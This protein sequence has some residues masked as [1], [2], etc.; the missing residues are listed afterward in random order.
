[1]I[2]VMKKNIL[3]LFLAVLSVC[4]LFAADLE[5][6]DQHYR[7]ISLCSML[8]KHSEDKFAKEIEEHF[9]VIP[10]SEQYNDHNL[11]VRVV[12]VDKKGKYTPNIHNFVEANEIASR[13]VAKW[14]NRNILTGECDV[15]LVKERGLYDASAFDIELSK[16]S[17]RG[18]AMLADAGED[19]IGRT[20]LLVNEIVYIDKGKRSRTWGAVLGALTAVAG[21]A[22]GVDTSDLADLTES[23]IS[24]IKGFKVKINTRLYRLNW[25][26]ENQMF[27]YSECYSEGKDLAKME[28]FEKGRGKFSMTYVG[29]VTSKGST[30]SFLGI[31]EDQPELMIRKACQRAIDENVADLQKAYDEFRIKTPIVS[32]EPTITAKIG[33]KEGIDKDS[34]FEVLEAEEK[35]GRIV[36][37]RV[38]VVKPIPTKIWD[39]RFMATEEGAYGAE[40]GATTF[41]KESGR[42]F[43]P[44]L[45]L[46]QIN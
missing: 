1:M 14:F 25:S 4:N 28:N 43:Y 7:R 26:E 39:N 38:G 30:T 46:R 16:R 2:L 41:V 11:S 40:F 5:V 32:V 22:A 35:D 23:M 6:K 34:R 10:I 12:S 45:L 24:S 31:N 29:D 17:Q 36:Y 8:V 44:G 37:K 3:L 19:L 42:D 18:M 33:L 20:Y 27:F 13:L 21:A 9:L 15:D